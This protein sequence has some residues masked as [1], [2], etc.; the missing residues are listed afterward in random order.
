MTLAART[1]ISSSID[2]MSCASASRC[3]PVSSTSFQ[4]LY[5]TVRSAPLVVQ[6]AQILPDPRPNPGI[7]NKGETILGRLCASSESARATIGYFRDLYL[8]WLFF[9]SSVTPSLAS[10]HRFPRWPHASPS[11]LYSPAP[12]ASKAPSSTSDIYR[13]KVPSRGRS[14]VS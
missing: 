2:T 4:Y 12:S 11:R 8:L 5:R 10:A 1:P 9:H 6:R 13:Y 3:V 14:D 7:I